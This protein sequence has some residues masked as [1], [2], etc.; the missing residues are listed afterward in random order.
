MVSTHAGRVS[1]FL[2]PHCVRFACHAITD[3]RVVFVSKNI[4]AHLQQQLPRVQSDRMRCDFLLRIIAC[5]KNSPCSIVDACVKSHAFLRTRSD[6]ER[7]Y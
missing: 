2:S 4:R 7:F 5:I 6:S 1:I 3:D